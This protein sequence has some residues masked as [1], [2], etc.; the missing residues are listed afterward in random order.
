MKKLF[1]VLSLSVLFACHGNE[2]AENKPTDQDRTKNNDT[3]A[4]LKDSSVVGKKNSTDTI[5]R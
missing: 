2:N 1:I 5:H 3:S 4:V